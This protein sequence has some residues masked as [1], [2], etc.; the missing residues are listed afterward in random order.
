M[1][2]R[3]LKTRQPQPLIDNWCDLHFRQ[4]KG[5]AN[6]VAEAAYTQVSECGSSSSIGN[7]DEIVILENVLGDR[8]AHRPGVELKGPVYFADSN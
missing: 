7:V 8:R 6:D 2:Q 3:N 5:W 4:G 1:I